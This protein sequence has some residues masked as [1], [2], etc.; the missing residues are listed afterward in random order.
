MSPSALSHEAV[1]TRTRNCRRARLQKRNNRWNWM[2]E[3]T[4]CY[5]SWCDGISWQ[6]SQRK[7]LPPLD[8]SYAR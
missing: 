3:A 5:C 6:R 7:Q 4:R 2:P 1:P 8:N